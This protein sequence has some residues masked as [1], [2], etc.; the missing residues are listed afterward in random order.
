MEL[1]ELLAVL[2]VKL[3]KLKVVESLDLPELMKKLT[4]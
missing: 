3:Q 1:Q 2:S 4:G